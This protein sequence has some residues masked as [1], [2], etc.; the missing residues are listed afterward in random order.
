MRVAVTSTGNELSADVDPRFGRCAWFIVVDTESG[1][2]EAVDNS[3]SQQAA[4]GAG[5]QAAQTVAR[6]GAQVVLTGNCGPKAYA[7]LQTAGIKVV[8]GATGTVSEALDK[9]KATGVPASSEEVPREHCGGKDK[10][11]GRR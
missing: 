6:H 2:W 9:L 7:A 4:H 1:A 3:A 11:S 8:E 5:I 10:H